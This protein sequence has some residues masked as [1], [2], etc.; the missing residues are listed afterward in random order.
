MAEGLFGADSSVSVTNQ[1][2][3]KSL[4]DLATETFGEPP[5]VWGRYFTSTSTGGSVE[6]RHL[7]ENQ[8]LRDAGIR[9]LPI[10]RQTKNVNGTQSEGSADA[11]LNSEDLID[12]FGADHLAGAGGNVFMFLDVEGSPSLSVAYYLGWAQ[13]IVAHSREYSG[14]KVS[15]LPCVYATQGDAATWKAVA[16]AV[17]LGCTC[18]GAWVARWKI[19]GCGE[20]IPWNDATVRL[21]VKIP[22]DVVLWQYADECHGGS[23]FDCNRINPN[24]DRNGFLSKCVLPPETLVS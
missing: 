16:D 24:I 1:I 10:A 15:I 23:G 22:C 2:N 11:Q 9:V 8:V 19:R 7:R 17:A 18:G 14:G 6:Y 13:T 21:T 5:V 4:I 3:G 20:P 12:T